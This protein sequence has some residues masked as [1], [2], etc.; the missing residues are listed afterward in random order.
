M[1]QDALKG[2][3]MEFIVIF[4]IIMSFAITLYYI[5]IKRIATILEEKYGTLE[6]ECKLFIKDQQQ[7]YDI[8][9]KRTSRNHRAIDQHYKILH[10]GIGRRDVKHISA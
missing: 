8:L 10:K 3:P 9:H 7:S 1:R 5:K 2:I 4:A 6:E